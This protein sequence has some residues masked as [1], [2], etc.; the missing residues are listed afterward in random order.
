M[1]GKK[2]SA[3]WQDRPGLLARLSFDAVA[4]AGVLSR[5]DR[6]SWRDELLSDVGFKG[7]SG[8]FRFLPGGANLRAFELRQIENGASN[9][10]Q[11]APDRI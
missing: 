2:W 11:A 3:V 7:V 1:F 9:L 5:K 6:A 10:L 8:A 4:L